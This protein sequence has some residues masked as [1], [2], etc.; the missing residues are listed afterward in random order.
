MRNLN[1]FG[2]AF[3]VISDP[4]GAKPI[5]AFILKNK[6][7][8]TEFYILSDKLHSFYQD[9]DLPIHLKNKICKNDLLQFS[10]DFII[11]ATSHKSNIEIH[12]LYLAKKIKLKSYVYIDHSTYIL[13]RFLFR[14]KYVFPD[15]ILACDKYVKNELIFQGFNTKNIIIL[16]NPYLLWLAKWTPSIS[17][18]KFFEKFGLDLTKKTLLYLPDPLSN[19][20]DALNQFGYDEIIATKELNI[21]FKKLKS[22]YNILLK[23]HPNQNLIKFNSIKNKQFIVLDT[24]SDINSFFYYS[25][26]IIGFFSN[27]LIE[28]LIFK[29]KVFR[30]QPINTIYDP[31]KNRNI[32]TVSNIN[33]LL[34]YLS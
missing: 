29:K 4:G 8:F 11:T 20:S 10:P 14:K 15:Y 32:G 6:N 27:S 26:Y 33:T 18:E 23:P 21:L 5:L 3:F 22:N 34:K 31:L 1:L 2:R 30:Y 19:K 12:A 25:D 17:K 28:A 7:K 9:F 24:N 13:E 16:N